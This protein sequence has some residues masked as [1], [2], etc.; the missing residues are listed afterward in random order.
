[1]HNES[2][3]YGDDT[4]C[5]ISVNWQVSERVNMTLSFNWASSLIYGS[6]LNLPCRY[7]SAWPWLG[8]VAVFA[9][10]LQRL[11]N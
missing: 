7:W 8:R 3:C 1:M 10:K 11:I 4:A 2:R 6:A 9:L 5:R